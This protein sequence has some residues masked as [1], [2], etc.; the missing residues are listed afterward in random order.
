MQPPSVLAV[1]GVESV[2][3]AEIRHHQ[4]AV[5]AKN[6]DRLVKGRQVPGRHLHPGRGGFTGL[7]EWQDGWLMHHP[8]TI[9][10]SRL[11][12]SHKVAQET[13]G[14]QTVGRS[15]PPPPHLT[16]YQRKVPSTCRHPLKPLSFSWYPGRGSNPQAFRRWIL[17]EPKTGLFT[18]KTSSHRGQLVL[19]HWPHL[20]ALFA[21]P[22]GARI[23]SRT[24]WL[25]R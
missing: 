19:E 5:A 17:S 10:P 25:A 2:V 6:H 18:F 16:P 21:N 22:R 20:Y 9:P 3:E 7:L 11:L 23:K 1:Y 24:N 12:V 13:M 15:P 14:R 4:L 8:G